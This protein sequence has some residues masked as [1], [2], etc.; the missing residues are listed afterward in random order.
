MIANVCITCTMSRAVV[1]NS[2]SNKGV[3]L[4]L[5]VSIKFYIHGIPYRISCV[6]KRI[7]RAILPVSNI[8][9]VYAPELHFTLSYLHLD[10]LF[11]DAAEYSVSSRRENV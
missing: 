9:A 6:L 1:L 2:A 11:V 3:S 5:R 10:L 7:I 8:A 4:L